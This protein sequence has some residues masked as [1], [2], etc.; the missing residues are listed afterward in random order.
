MNEGATQLLNLGSFVDPDFADWTVDVNWGDGSS[1]ASFTVSADGSISSSLSYPDDGV[2]PVTVTV[3][4]KAGAGKSDTKSFD[5]TVQGVDPVIFVADLDVGI[6]QYGTLEIPV[7]VSDPGFDNPSHPIAATTETFTY[8]ID[9]KD[10][11]S[12]TGVV[13]IETPGAAGQPTVAAIDLAHV[14]QAQGSYFAT[15]TVTDDDGDF[16]QVDIEISVGPPRRDFGDAPISYA[17]RE[18]EDGARHV[19]RGVLLGTIRDDESNG[20]PSPNAD[21]DDVLNTDDEDGIVFTSPL[22]AGSTASADVTASEAGLLDAWIDF[23]GDGAWQDDEQIATSLAVSAG[24]NPI[25]FV[26]DPDAFYVNQSFARFRISSAGGLLPTGL[27]DDGEVEDY[28]VTFESQEILNLGPLGAGVAGLDYAAGNGYLMFSQ[29]SVHDRFDDVYVS[30]ADH[31]IS[32]QYRSGQWHYSGNGA[33]APF[34]PEASDRLLAKVDFTNDVIEDLQGFGGQIQGIDQGYISSDIG[35]IAN[36]FAGNP[37]GGEFT[38]TG[39]SITVSESPS[40]WFDLGRLGLGIPGPD[41]S[42]QSGYILYSSEDVHTRFASAPILASA[43]DHLII[44]AYFG[45]R[46]QINDNVG[47][48]DFTPQDNDRLLAKID[49]GANTISSLEGFGGEIK[50]IDQ[51]F[52]SGDLTFA[53]DQFNGT[54][55]AGEFEIGGT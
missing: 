1:D 15:L 21:G 27:A 33:F 24:V 22:L 6:D 46:W 41:A 36:Q 16:D 37:N 7:S 23:D 14:Y 18:I 45:G 17:T 3:T 48:H 50:G 29:Q 44:A 20:R 39:S 9:W 25:S 11:E 13:P 51:G 47:W 53:A 34:V 28:A 10:G 43:S 5:V 54:S 35:F 55:N 30:S 38:V 8:S 2:Y 4:D 12:D 32:V 49:M 19:A 31:V 52:T 42:V 26:V 40:R